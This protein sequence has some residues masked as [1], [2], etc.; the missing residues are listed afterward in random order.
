MGGL[1]TMRS[2]SG[3]GNKRIEQVQNQQDRSCDVIK[4]LTFHIS[5]FYH[6]TWVIDKHFNDKSRPKWTSFQI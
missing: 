4:P 6:L 2:H 1:Q 5:V 3:F